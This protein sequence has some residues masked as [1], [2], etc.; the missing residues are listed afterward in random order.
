[1]R[2]QLTSRLAQ[3][4]PVYDADSVAPVV[5]LEGRSAT[6]VSHHFVPAAALVPLIDRPDGM[7]ILLTQRTAHLNDH[8]GQISFPGGR[9]E[10]DDENPKATAL[11]ETEEEIGLS[12]K[13]IDVVGYLDLSVTGTGFLVT[14]V[15]GLISLGFTLSLDEFEVAEV[16]E[17]PL[18]YVLNPG[19][20]QRES[21]VLNG[22]KRSFYVIEYEHRYVWGATAGMLVNLY[23]KLR[24]R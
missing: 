20:H 3:S 19:N 16:F 6:A 13:F 5:D 12:P 15:V 24:E 2:Q 17:I 7:T 23:E 14:P 21:R 10:P 18:A 4:Q 9:V 22:V 11:R 8:A 1:M